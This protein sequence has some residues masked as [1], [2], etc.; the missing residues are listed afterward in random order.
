MKNQSSVTASWF[1]LLVSLW[2]ASFTWNVFRP[3]YAPASAAALSFA[4]GWLTS[5]L[6]LHP[7][8]WQTIMPVVF[9][10]AGALA[11]WPGWLGLA[12]TLASWIGLA[13]WYGRAHEAAVA[14]EEALRFALGGDYGARK[15]GPV[16]DDAH[17][18]AAPARAG[19]EQDRH[20]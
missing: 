13:G 6:A 7:L 17:S 19:L 3:R 11:G 8:L 20:L 2:G 12:I 10:W 4:A 5:T 14:V 18:L 1:F 16:P 9:V 15:L